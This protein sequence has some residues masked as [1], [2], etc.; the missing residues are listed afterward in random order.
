MFAYTEVFSGCHWNNLKKYYLYF[1][2]KTLGFIWN[3]IFFSFGVIPTLNCNFFILPPLSNVQPQEKGCYFSTTMVDF[4][5]IV[6]LFTH[7]AVCVCWTHP[8]ESTTPESS[9]GLCPLHL[10]RHPL[11]SASAKPEVTI[12]TCFVNHVS[13]LWVKLISTTLFP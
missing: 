4:A 6:I 3:E 7:T 5:L 1:S 2:Y 8:W 9:I 10:T 11:V 12:C 13:C